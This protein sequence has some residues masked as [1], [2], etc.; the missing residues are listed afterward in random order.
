MIE[1]NPVTGAIFTTNS[2]GTQVNGN[3]LYL[4]KLDVYHLGRV[5]IISIHLSSC[6]VR[7]EDDISHGA[8]DMLSK[9]QRT[10]IRQLQIY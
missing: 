10:F 9:L 1:R 5:D 6:W 4:K 8:L 2:T 7:R 3:I